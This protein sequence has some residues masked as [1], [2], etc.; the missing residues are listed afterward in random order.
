MRHVTKNILPLILAIVLATS[1]FAATVGE[2]QSRADDLNAT[3][4]SLISRAEACPGGTCSDGAAIRSEFATADTSRL[5]LK[6]DRETLN[7]CT[8]CSTLDETIATVDA[9][10]ATMR[11]ILDGWD[12]KS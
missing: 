3:C 7:P 5:A 1:A 4:G 11:S 8:T 12:G 10:A 9:R 6:A 2:L